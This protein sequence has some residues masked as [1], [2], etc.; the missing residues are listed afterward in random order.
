[1]TVAAIE[2]IDLCRNF[3]GFQA[4]SNVSLRVEKDTVHGIIGPNGA[5]KTTFFNLLTKFLTPSAG[6]ILLNGEDVTA[7]PPDRVARRGLVR[8][9]QISAIF[10]NMTVL[11]NIRIALLRSSPYPL[12]FWRSES[13]LSEFD[14]IAC[15]TLELVDLQDYRNLLAGDLPYGRRR[16]LEL[17]TTIALQPKVILLDEPTQGMGSEDIGLVVEL[18]GRVAKNRTVVLVEHNMGV[19]AKLCNKISVLQRGQILAEGSYDDVSNNPTVMQAY[20]GSADHLD[21]VRAHV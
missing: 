20:M 7:D 8:S 15:E 3:A 14:A 11:Q 19:V 10:P 16:S 4:V 12:Q 5:G 6:R 13:V 18:I 2:T 17:A 1:M 21:E 9:F